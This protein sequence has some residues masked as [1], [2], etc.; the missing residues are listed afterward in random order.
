MEFP[1]HPFWDFAIDVYRRPGVSDA[2]LQLQERHRLDVNLLLF[3]CWIG[4]SGRGRLTPEEIGHCI[5]A[6]RPWHE[7]VVRP[8]R[9]VRRMLKGDLGAAPVELAQALRREIQ[10]REIDAE[11]IEQLMLAAA[12]PRQ[13]QGNVLP[14]TRLADASRNALLYLVKLGAELDAATKQSLAVILG[15]AV[16]DMA[17][18]HV[19]ETLAAAAS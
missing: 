18:D 17:S 12:L 6:V 15:Q 13:P 8:M 2:C 16:P 19:R 9:G 3:A 14:A 10:A 7:A 1:P 4:V 11:H 5:D